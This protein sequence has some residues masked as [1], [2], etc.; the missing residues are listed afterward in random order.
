MNSPNIMRAYDFIVNSALFPLIDQNINQNEEIVLTVALADVT[1]VLYLLRDD[2]VCQ[3]K[4][5]IDIF[6]VDYLGKKPRFEVIYNLLSIKY[7]LRC[8]IK[9]KLNEDEQVP[10]IANIYQGAIW[11]EREAYDMY[12]I[13]FSESPD[14]R[15]I[16]T[17]YGFDG[18]PLRKD[19]PL[20]GYV[21]VK[22]SNVEKKVV[23]EPV[24]LPQEY[25]DFD[26]LSPWDGPNYV[27]PGDEK[28]NSG[29]PTDARN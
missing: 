8:I 21:E 13:I 16:L 25:R 2:S 4:V 23:Y 28:A 5:L 10:S 24:S 11:F 17:D 3:F 22:Y 29:G 26:C 12:G 1:K 20:S 19:F 15:R 7:N 14:L 27:L 18:H 6:A 9:V